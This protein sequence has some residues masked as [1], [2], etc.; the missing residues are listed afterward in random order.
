MDKAKT[1]DKK[2]LCYLI[3]YQNNIVSNKYKKKKKRK[4]NWVY[5]GWL[6]QNTPGK[7]LLT[8]ISA[9]S[10]RF[11][12]ISIHCLLAGGS[13]LMTVSSAMSVAGTV[14][15]KMKKNVHITSFS[16]RFRRIKDSSLETVDATHLKYF[17]KEFQ[18]TDLLIIRNV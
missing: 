2:V 15:T 4:E 17:L 9:D 5:F 18:N 14:N 13:S 6:Q 3:L 7:R 8:S 10:T 16:D 12:I 11:S 1:L